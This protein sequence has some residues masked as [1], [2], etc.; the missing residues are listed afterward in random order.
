M[1]Y[2]QWFHRYRAGSSPLAT[3]SS[4]TPGSASSTDIPPAPAPA[5]PFHSTILQPL[6][7]TKQ[8]THWKKSPN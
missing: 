8:K 4:S 3:T 7:H 5:S 2:D 1:T 6:P